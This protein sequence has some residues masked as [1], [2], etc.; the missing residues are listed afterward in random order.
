MALDEALNEMNWD[1]TSIP[2][3]ARSVL[4]RKADGYQLRFGSS[5]EC[6]TLIVRQDGMILCDANLHG[7]VNEIARTNMDS[8][9]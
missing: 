8:S 2:F 6:G 3:E 1:R 7:I 5:E 4:R 9:L